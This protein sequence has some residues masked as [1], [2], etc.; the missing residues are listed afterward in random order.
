M[1]SVS[2]LQHVC[3]CVGVH[4][5]VAP[6]VQLA[7]VRKKCYSECHCQSLSVPG[8]VC[9]LLKPFSGICRHAQHGAY[10][11]AT[12]PFVF[13]FHTFLAKIITEWNFGCLWI[14]SE[15]K[16]AIIP[17]RSN[18]GSWRCENCEIYDANHNFIWRYTN[19]VTL[20]IKGGSDFRKACFILLFWLSPQWTFRLVIFIALQLNE[21]TFH[22]DLRC[23]WDS[24]LQHSAVKIY[25]FC[26][27]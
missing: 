3:A 17:G 9:A 25:S 11:A 20:S 13:D 4:V 7:P 15:K 18:S 23:D 27:F 24:D 5:Q 16:W 22:R 19:F 21:I 6:L 14:R 10:T 2:A 26:T 12:I 1:V 8:E